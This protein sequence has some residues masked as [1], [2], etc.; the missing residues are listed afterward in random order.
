MVPAC[1]DERYCS[2]E[3]AR[4]GIVVTQNP[5]PARQ[6]RA[7]AEKPIVAPISGARTAVYDISAHAVYLPDGRRLEAHSGLGS[8]KDNPSDAHLRM[9][10]PTPP[11][12]YNLKLRERPFHGV[13][14][15]RLLP[16]DPSRMHGRAGIL[17]HSYML[18]SRGDSKGCVSIR[19]YPAFLYAYL[20]GL[21][22]RIVVVGKG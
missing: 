1:A 22:T 20:R 21:V 5:R 3:P 12:V 10:G 2:I 11:N 8:S 14:A 7:V 9:R 6:A 16:T 19:D 13:R 4:L 17:A 18:G 15:I